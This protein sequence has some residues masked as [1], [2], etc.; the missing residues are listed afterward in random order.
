MIIIWL[1]GKKLGIKY[2]PSQFFI[3]SAASC[4]SFSRVSVSFGIGRNGACQSVIPDVCV[5]VLIGSGI[6]GT[7]NMEIQMLSAVTTFRTQS[8]RQF[9]KYLFLGIL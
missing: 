9:K 5:N 6:F 4:D 1:P 8:F 3:F 2:G 7:Y